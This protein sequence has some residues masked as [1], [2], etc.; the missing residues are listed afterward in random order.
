[1]VTQGFLQPACWRVPCSL[2]STDFLRSTDVKQFWVLP[3]LT[4]TASGAHSLLEMAKLK[5][6]PQLRDFSFMRFV[7]RLGGFGTEDLPP[8]EVV[9]E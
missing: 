2:L 8:P 7:G 5:V 6:G 9:I 4:H 3:P 1:M